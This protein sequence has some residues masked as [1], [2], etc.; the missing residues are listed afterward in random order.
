MILASP[1]PCS[2][3]LVVTKK[4]ARGGNVDGSRRGEE[5]RERG[6]RTQRGKRK[7]R[8]RAERERRDEILFYY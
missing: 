1:R 3:T 7:R 8:T 2:R 6:G 4:S 5:V